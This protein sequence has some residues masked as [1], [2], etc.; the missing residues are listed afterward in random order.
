MHLKFFNAD[1]FDFLVFVTNIKAA[2]VCDL[3][4]HQHKALVVLDLDNTLVDA[5]AV[6]VTQKDW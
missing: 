5:M 4:R 1:G 3:L 6:A 2:D